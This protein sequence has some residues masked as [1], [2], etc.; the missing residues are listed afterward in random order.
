M[1]N[2]ND[3]LQLRKRKHGERFNASGL[4]SQFIPYFESGQR[5]KV[6]FKYGEEL[7]GTVGITTGWVPSFLLMRT[8]RS[9]GSAWLLGKDDQI[10]EVTKYQ[11]RRKSN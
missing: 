3:L 11:G 4:A 10:V 1:R 2:Y 6:R 5:I 7:T 9:I 8:S